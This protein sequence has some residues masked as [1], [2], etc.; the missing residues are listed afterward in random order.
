MLRQVFLNPIQD[1][2]YSTNK[3]I[4][5]IPKSV[6]EALKHPGWSDAMKEEMHIIDVTHTWDL[7]PFDETMNV[8]GCRWVFTV[9]LNADGSLNRL[10][11]R[12]VAKDLLQ[13]EGID[14]TETFSPVVKTA[15]I[16]IVLA[17]VTAKSWPLIQFD[18]K[19]AFLHGDL[20]EEV[21]MT[22]PPGFVN[23]TYPNHVCCLK[24]SLCC[25]KKAPRAWFEKFA[26]FY[27][28]LAFIV[29]QQ[30]RLSSSITTMAILWFF[31]FMSTI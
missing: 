6:V 18:V 20:Q 1:T 16:R 25:L 13:E 3:T 28:S 22:Q 17:V 31:F 12:L 19:N 11:A 5:G 15:T 23:P 29:V 9:K 26:N 27:W 2:F 14:F 10:K 8:L 4:P 24:K 30:T 21:F 7:I